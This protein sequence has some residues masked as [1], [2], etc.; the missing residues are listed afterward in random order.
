MYVKA[1][2]TQTAEITMTAY[3]V[4]LAYISAGIDINV[5]P[6]MWLAISDAAMGKKFIFFPPNKYSVVLFCFFFEMKP[7]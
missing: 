1:I 5:I 7:K 4:P 3:C 2:P 6:L